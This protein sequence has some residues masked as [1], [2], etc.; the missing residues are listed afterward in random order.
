MKN[1]KGQ[2]LIEIIIAFGIA[3]I[4]L[5]AIVVG[6]TSTREGRVQQQ[7]RLD[8]T[9]LYKEAVDAVRTIRESGWENI[10]A[11]GVYHP[12]LI[13]SNWVLVAGEEIVGDFTRTVSIKDTYRD[14]NGNI[15]LIGGSLDPS[16]K[17]ITVLVSWSNIFFSSVSSDMYVVRYLGNASYIETLDTEFDLGTLSGTVVTVSDDGEVRLSPGGSTSWCSPNLDL[18]PL[19]LPKQ[20]VA[21][22]IS[23]IE[24]QAFVG[25]GDNAS[26]VS[27]ADVSITNENPPGLSVADTFD[28]YKTNDVFGES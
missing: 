21:N 8:A 25:T 9:V 16:T 18:S 23:A 1:N 24:G 28:G 13:D 27:F 15:T 10:S 19:D 26:G 20:G 12:E 22:A 14:S 2:S 17:K 11:N 7:K 4:F 5:P 3:S 6:F